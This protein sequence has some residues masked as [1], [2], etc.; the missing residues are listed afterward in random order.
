MRIRVE[1]KE[2]FMYAVFLYFHQERPDPED[3]S[4]KAYLEANELVPKHQGTDKKEDGEFDVM[5][6]GGC[7]LGKHLK[8]IEDMQRGVV[9]EEMLTQEIKRALH[10]TGEYGTKGAQEVPP[11]ELV[12]RLVQVR[13]DSLGQ[14]S[15][16]PGITPAAVSALNIFLGLDRKT[17]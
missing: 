16:I 9:E 7:Y 1:P 10:E 5:Y 6:F 11:T 14:A 3:A 13:P 17:P 8:T 15:R 2:F 4:V 12:E